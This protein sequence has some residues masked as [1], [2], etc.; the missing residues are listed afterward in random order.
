ME[1]KKINFTKK[2]IVVLLMVTSTGVLAQRNL[3]HFEMEFST[4][5][6]AANYERFITDH[7]SLGAKLG[8][9]TIGAE[10]NYYLKPMDYNIWNGHIGISY[11]LTA[12]WPILTSIYGPT[13]VLGVDHISSSGFFIGLEG[14]AM[15]AQ[16]GDLTDANP[17]TFYPMINFKIGK[18]LK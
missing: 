10:A 17:R 12:A 15:L 1:T 8:I 18:L 6:F 13:A 7:F 16:Y 14:G 9:V 3:I 2:I 11:D 5:A 4:I